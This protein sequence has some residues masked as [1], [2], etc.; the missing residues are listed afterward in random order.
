L[1][2]RFERLIAG[3][4]FVIEVTW[5]ADKRWRAHI[6]RIPGVPA[7]MMPFYGETPDEA[8]SQLSNWLNRAHQTQANTV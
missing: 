2:H 6:V 4:T 8:A 5:V 3:R 7:A 1:R